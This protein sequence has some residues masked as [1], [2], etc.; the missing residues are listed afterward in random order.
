M[1]VCMPFIF[2]EFV[3]KLKNAQLFKQKELVKKIRSNSYLPTYCY[4]L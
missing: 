3:Q 4:Y 2:F 1:L